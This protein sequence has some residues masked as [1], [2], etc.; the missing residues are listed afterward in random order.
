MGATREQDEK[1]LDEEK[2]QQALDELPCTAYNQR[3]TWGVRDEEDWGVETAYCH[4]R[5]GKGLSQV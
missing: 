4:H 5:M 1:L 2:P 3:G